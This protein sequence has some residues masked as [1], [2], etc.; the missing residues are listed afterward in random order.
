LSLSVFVG[1]AGIAAKVI[2]EPLDGDAELVV[3]LV[4]ALLNLATDLGDAL[5]AAGGTIERA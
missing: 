3:A 5:T 1:G 2:E 4:G